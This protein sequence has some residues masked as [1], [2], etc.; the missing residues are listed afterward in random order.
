[1]T[2]LS[3]CLAKLDRAQK[4][5][6]ELKAVSEDYLSDCCRIE[7][8]VDLATTDKIYRAVDVKDMPIEVSLILGDVLHNLRCSLDH[9]IH[10]VVISNGQEPTNRNEFPIFE[11]ETQYEKA[12]RQKLKG[13]PASKEQLIRRYQPFNAA[14]PR[15]TL[16]WMLQ[17][18]NNVDKHRLIVVCV[19]VM[20]GVNPGHNANLPTD[21]PDGILG[22]FSV[23]T[24]NHGML[25]EGLVLARVK[26]R[27]RLGFDIEPTVE[28]KPEIVFGEMFEDLRYGHLSNIIELYQ[29]IRGHV[30]G[31]SGLTEGLVE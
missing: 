2:G 6:D 7:K 30:F 5:I 17:Q 20:V 29:F 21:G 14:E 16:F 4:H 28:L 1:M 11:S 31:V 3:G 9:L 15:K 25:E 13:V 22:S 27:G 12:V 24:I 23:D 26:I 8:K 18:M 19:P 10:T